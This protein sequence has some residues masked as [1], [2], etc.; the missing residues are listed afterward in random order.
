MQV[1]LGKEQLQFHKI[2]E[3]TFTTFFQEK[4]AWKN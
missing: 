2:A 4:K 3:A 1:V